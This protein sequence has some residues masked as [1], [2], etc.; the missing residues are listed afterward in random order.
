VR[1]HCA[2]YSLHSSVVEQ[3][4]GHAQPSQASQDCP[5]VAPAVRIWV[6]GERGHGSPLPRV[7]DAH[8]AVRANGQHGVAVR[9]QCAAQRGRT[10]PGQAPVVPPA[11]SCSCRRR[12]AAQHSL[13]GHCH[14]SLVHCGAL[15]QDM[16]S[17]LEAL[18][19]WRARQSLHACKL[20]CYTRAHVEHTPVDRSGM[21]WHAC[22]HACDRSKCPDTQ[23][24]CS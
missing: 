20:Q 17:T 13:Y 7:K 12:A 8:C 9:L 18:A 16:R 21:A 11:A 4:A 15:A 3:G 14:T 23:L 19:C 10:S 1:K 6:H 2:S 5:S 24:R 22:M